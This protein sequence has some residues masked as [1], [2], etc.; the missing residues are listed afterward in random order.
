M[1]PRPKRRRERGLEFHGPVIMATR[2]VLVVLYTVP[3]IWILLTSLKST[4]DAVNPHRLFRFTPTLE[5]YATAFRSGILHAGLQSLIIA[6]GTT[7]LVLLVALPAA[8][9][10]ARVPG[11]VAI[12]GL[13]I[14]VTLQML[15]QTATVIPLFQVLGKVGL[16]DSILGVILSNAAML[17][18][19]ATLLL[20]P[21]FRSVPAAIEESAALD[22]A[23]SLRTFFSIMLP[24]ARNGAAT[25]GTLVFILSWGEFLY[26]ITFLLSPTKYPLSA[27]LAVQIGQFS[28]NWSGLMTVAVLTALPILVLFVFTYRLLREG[29]TLGAV[30]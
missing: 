29:L 1:S 24:I 22:G 26:S 14:L 10:L 13:G 17:T 15:P 28:S 21:F 3:V 7:A 2:V 20:R 18:P 19:W 25:T 9:G 5:S 30:K 27:K 16:I 23:S 4:A 11:P 8:Y 12:G 6:T